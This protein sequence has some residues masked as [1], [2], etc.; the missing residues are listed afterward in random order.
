LFWFFES[1]KDPSNAPL[2]IWL[3]GGPGASSIASALGENGPCI[4]SEDSNSTTLNPWSWNNKVNMLYIDQPVQVGFSYDVLR[5]GTFDA[6]SQTLLP[7]IVDF[8]VSGVPEQNETFFVGTF[9][10]LSLNSTANSTGNAAPAAWSFLQTWLQEYVSILS[11]VCLLTNDRFPL[12]KSPE[13]RLS[14][15]AESYGGHWGPGV[16]AFIEHQ[17][18]EIRSGSLKNAS[19]IQLDTLGIINGGIDFA[20]TAASYPDIAYNNTYGFQAMSKADYEA[21]LVNPTACTALVDK[22]QQ[23]AASYDPNNYG[24]NVTINSAC[25][26]AY[27]YCYLYVEADFLKSGVSLLLK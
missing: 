12:Y 3:N 24:N 14:I 10:F 9:P 18:D 16:A 8:S 1:R 6:L 23:L 27:G 26:S 20:I 5:N 15:W 13:N 19:I 7:T 22:C 17:N 2:S 25:S 11:K 21:L 4:V